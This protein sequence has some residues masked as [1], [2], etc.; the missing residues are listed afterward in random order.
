M[1]FLYHAKN[2]RLNYLIP[3]ML[4][5]VP[6]I[7]MRELHLRLNLRDVWIGIIASGVLLPAAIILNLAG[8]GF[9]IPEPLSFLVYQLFGVALPE[10]IYF[11]GFIQEAMGNNIRAIVVVSILF[12]VMHIPQL[13]FYGEILSL[14]TFFPSLI[15]GFL[16]YRTGN[17]LTPTVFHFM[18][19]MFYYGFYTKS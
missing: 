19:N 14:L 1:V 9:H 18:S 13:I 15:M 2:Q 5:L 6:L 12:S 8:K 11:R 10:E 16:Y 17:I 4:Y 3:L 7:T